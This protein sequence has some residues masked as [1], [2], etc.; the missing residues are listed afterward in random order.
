[1]PKP[2]RYLLLALL[3]L[4]CASQAFADAYMYRDRNGQI[5][6]TDKPMHGP[7]K[8]L[9]RISLGNKPRSSGDTLARM[10]ERRDRYAPLIDVAARQNRLTPE[11]VHAVVRA[12]SAYRPDAVSSKG[13]M[14][15]MQLMPGTAKRFGVTDAHDPQQNVQ[16]GSRYLRQLL[17]MFD[18]DLRLALAAYNAGENAVIRHGYQVPPYRETQ[19]Y[20]ERVLAFYKE[21]QGQPRLAAADPR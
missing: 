18:K 11:L 9:K 8:L 15:L 14:G 19:V 4:I 12:E 5:H 10:R 7:Y 1:M 2:S 3:P 16:A 17:E 13:A 6:L 21:H 20:V